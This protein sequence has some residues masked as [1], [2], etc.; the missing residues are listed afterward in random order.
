L[1]GVAFDTLYYTLLGISTSVETGQYV[2][3]EDAFAQWRKGARD[4][5]FMVDKALSGTGFLGIE[6]TDWENVKQRS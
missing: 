3:Y 5:Y 1:V 2:I 4:G 6:G